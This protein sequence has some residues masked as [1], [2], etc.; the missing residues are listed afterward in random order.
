VLKDK[1]LIG[2][3]LNGAQIMGYDTAS[4]SIVRQ[5]FSAVVAE[6]CMKSSVIHP[7]ENRYNF[8]EADSLVNFA[9]RNDITV[10][11]HCLIWHSQLS[12]WFC[13][14]KD[15]KEV[16][17]EV[18]RSRMREH[19]HTVVGR[20]KGR[21]RGWDVVNE[22]IIED[23]SYRDSPFYRILGKEF[24]PLAFQYAH[25]ADPD[26]ELYYNDY[27]MNEAGRRDGVVQLVK[28]LKAAGLRID[29]VGMQG[30]MGMEYPSLHDFEQSMLA[31]A[32][33]GV[34]VM[35]TEWDM[36]ALPT[37]TRSANIS[38]TAA[39]RRSLNPYPDELPDS[40]SQVWNGRMADFMRLFIRHAD[41]ITRVTAWGVTDADS[42]KNGFPV[43]GRKDYPLLFDRAYQPKPFV[44][45]LLNPKTAAFSNYSYTGEVPAADGLPLLPGCYPDPSICRVG[46][47]YYLVNSSFGFFP[48]IPIWHS[49]DMKTWERLG[50][51]LNRPEQLPLYTGIN[52]TGQGI[53]APAISYNPQNQTFYLVTTDVG[54][55]GNFYVTTDDP[56][57][58][59]WSHP[60]AL[61][62]VGGIDP[63]FFFDTDGRAYIVNNDIPAGKIRYDGHRAIRIREFDPVSG[64]TIGKEQVLIDGGVDPSTKPIWIEGPHL[65]HI[66]DTYYLMAAEGGTST[67]H[68]EVIF[69]APSPMGPFT[70]CP[71]NPILTQRDLPDNRPNPVTATGHA[72]L[73]QTPNGAWYAVF[74]GIRPYREGHD[75]MGRETFLHPVTWEGGQPIILP[76]GKVLNYGVRPTATQIPTASE[77]VQDAFY[78]RTPQTPFF[79]VE[80]NDLIIDARAVELNE[81]RQPAAVGHWVTCNDFAAA[82]TLSFRPENTGDFAGFCL[83]H[84]DDHYI[85]FGKSMNEENTP[86]LLLEAVCAKKTVYSTHITDLPLG[87]TLR[88]Y[89]NGS[90][91]GHYSFAYGSGDTDHQTPLGEPLTAD[92]LSTLTTGG[93]TGT[94]LGLCANGNYNKQ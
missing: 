40:V 44:R 34:K 54:G 90:H 65:Y 83:F 11:G 27:G 84:D 78:I 46:D 50:Y 71:V 74:L 93:F 33:T 81:W 52:V 35:I 39:F 2:T 7:E 49:H 88:L 30:H 25:E 15:G 45:E 69:S 12:P 61:P 76:R 48:G 16:S 32:A 64:T 55:M 14:D 70:P 60:I 75:I 38:D 72:D 26:A 51:V 41:I 66:G 29:A 28:E 24:I 73:V 22:A 5:H 18:L 43:R 80:G 87:E 85:R 82:V 17:P 23:G 68:S 8:T 58:G 4:L 94:M 91:D 1:F 42:W 89:I 9:L 57:A 92:W 53:Y 10:T 62:E 77:F 19:I 20:Y 47:D 56:K 21:I 36:S 63:S 67:Q 37:P 86:I 79:R 3:A 31:F 59:N 13:V 6:N